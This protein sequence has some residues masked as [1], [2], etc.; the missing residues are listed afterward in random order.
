MAQ[1]QPRATPG[2]R[3]Q[4]AMSRSAVETSRSTAP[5]PEQENTDTAKDTDEEVI[6]IPK[7]QID[8]LYA[9]I[10]DLAK[11][12]AEKDRAARQLTASN[13][14]SSPSSA[15]SNNSS[16]N[17][18]KPPTMRRTNERN[19][20]AFQNPAKQ[21]QRGSNPHQPHH[22]A[23]SAASTLSHTDIR[24]LLDALPVYTGAVDQ[25]FKWW[26]EQ[27]ESFCRTFN[28]RMSKVEWMIAGVLV[29]GRALEVYKQ[30]QRDLYGGRAGNNTSSNQSGGGGV[31]ASE[32]SSSSNNNA[33]TSTGT[34][35]SWR[36]ALPW[37]VVTRE[38][39]KLDNPILRSLHLHTQIFNLRHGQGQFQGQTTL[40]AAGVTA[41]VTQFRKLETQLDAAPLGDRL[42]LL[43]RVLPEARSM[44]LDKVKK[45]AAY[46]SHGADEVRQQG[47]G[48]E[49]HQQHTQL[50]FNNM[51]EVCD[52]VLIH[53]AELLKSRNNSNSNNS[54]SNGGG[55]YSRHGVSSSYVPSPVPSMPAATSSTQS[56]SLPASSPSST[57]LAS[58]S[59]LQQQPILKLPSTSSATPL[60]RIPQ[61]PT[62]T[63]D[64]VDDSEGT[65][66]PTPTPT[67]TSTTPSS[68]LSA[69]SS[70]AAV[71]NFCGK[72]GHLANK[73]FKRKKQRQKEKSKMY[74]LIQSQSQQQ[75]QLNLDKT[76]SQNEPE[77]ET[78]PEPEHEQET[79]HEPKHEPEHGQEQEQQHEVGKK[80]T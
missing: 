40:D 13:G 6:S 76:G 43:L 58:T 80:E 37:N 1:E 4:S 5:M 67:T 25:S 16:S 24:A 32:N 68:S 48:E 38:L 41:L 19:S 72:S 70:S 46:T 22:P 52:F 75:Q 14:S 9:Q 71:C 69:A 45:T 53:L 57:N 31:S 28:V 63:I 15:N 51:D 77:Q 33:T 21:L 7:S 34:G 44:I 42:W 54:S 3:K 50:A 74:D 55:G 65:P 10:N 23:P 61:P 39:S 12:V 35:S 8:L 36:R 26:K 56:P 47:C 2:P 30:V 27:V 78:E 20:T 60:P 29:K 11:S 59:S 17:V 64:D 49:Q 18:Y 66:T 79:E 62:T 73:C